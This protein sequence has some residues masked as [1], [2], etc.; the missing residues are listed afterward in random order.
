MP[1]IRRHQC[2][3]RRMNGS[4]G[5]HSSRFQHKVPNAAPSIF[6]AFLVH[7][8]SCWESLLCGSLG[9][10]WWRCGNSSSLRAFPCMF[11]SEIRLWNPKGKGSLEYAQGSHTWSQSA[12][13]YLMISGVHEFNLRRCF[14]I[15]EYPIDDIIDFQELRELGI[16][17]GAVKESQE[18]QNDGSWLHMSPFETTTSLKLWNRRNKIGWP[19]C[20]RVLPWLCFVRHGT[21]APQRNASPIC[22]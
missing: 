5:N 21:R 20:P 18:E 17:N 19:W 6:P 3:S 4:Q 7:A 9:S 2:V 13:D 22:C 12:R 1:C 16:S 14:E 15:S 8:P 11:R 10:C